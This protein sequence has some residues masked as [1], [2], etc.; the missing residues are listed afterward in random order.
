MVS[1]LKFLFASAT[2]RPGTFLL[3]DDQSRKP[4]LYLAISAVIILASYYILWPYDP[5]SYLQIPYPMPSELSA[6]EKRLIGVP[7]FTT[8]T[9]I[10]VSLPLIPAFFLTSGT[11]H[12]GMLYAC[13]CYVFATFWFFLWMYLIGLALDANFNLVGLTT[14]GRVGLLILI[15]ILL[16]VILYRLLESLLDE[17]G[18]AAFAQVCIFVVTSVTIY[19][20]V[21]YELVH[22]YYTRGNGM[23][24][25]LV[26]GDVFFVSRFTDAEFIPKRGNIIVYGPRPLEPDVD[27]SRVI[28]LPGEKIR[29][30]DGQVYVGGARLA[31][32]DGGIAHDIWSGRSWR[33][34]VRVTVETFRNGYRATTIDGTHNPDLPTIADQNF[35]TYTL[36]PCEYFVLGDNR[37]DS[38]DSRDVSHG[39]VRC[40]E[41][42]GVAIGK[43][44]PLFSKT[45]ILEL[46]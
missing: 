23:A 6:F 41:I 37:L 39:P 18:G 21:T 44:F 40:S 38:S 17:S 36:K 2:F 29:M 14:E 12:L 45:N 10:T 26:A 42:K 3:E 11:K 34:T 1:Y 31:Y 15:T 16:C 32:S 43:V 5:L 28:A 33:K 9:I 27:I 35:D 24:P 13:S 20:G 22:L 19:A 4:T 30:Q 7:V 8:L 25:T 46:H